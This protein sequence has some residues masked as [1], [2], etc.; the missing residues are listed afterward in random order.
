MD[1]ANYHGQIWFS[2]LT[3]KWPEHF[4]EIS[5]RPQMNQN[6]DIYYKISL[7]FFMEPIVFL[8]LAD[9]FQSLMRL[10]SKWKTAYIILE[11]LHFPFIDDIQTLNNFKLGE[12]VDCINPVELEIKDTT[13]SVWS[14]SYLWLVNWPWGST[15]K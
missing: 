4:I 14:A 12:Y 8:L 13:D 6:F 10:S 11:Q 9:K 1:T 5:H 2:Q 15:G 3:F 7:A